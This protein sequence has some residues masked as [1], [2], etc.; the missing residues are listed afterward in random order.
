MCGALSQLSTQ[1]W[2]T[3]GHGQVGRAW[4]LCPGRA[5][6]CGEGAGKGEEEERREQVSRVQKKEFVPGEWEPEVGAFK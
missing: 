6:R 5:S 4:R 3:W 2:G 1:L